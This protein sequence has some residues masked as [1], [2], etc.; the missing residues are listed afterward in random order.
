M[1][2][3]KKLDVYHVQ[4]PLL[5]LLPRSLTSFYSRL[6]PSLV[7]HVTC[8]GLT[9]L[10][11]CLAYMP[12]LSHASW[13]L[14][15]VQEWL[16]L[17]KFLASATSWTNTSS[18][19][20]TPANIRIFLL[21]LW[22]YFGGPWYT[23]LSVTL[24]QVIPNSNSELQRSLFSSPSRK[25]FYSMYVYPLPSQD[26]ALCTKRYWEKLFLEALKDHL[27]HIPEKQVANRLTLHSFVQQTFMSASNLSGTELPG[28]SSE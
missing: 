15:V 13:S 9:R 12:E 19:P 25:I 7:R 20:K 16:G 4:L 27:H 26:S 21:S 23:L 5:L 18:P 17:G 6:S 28:N 14:S 22:I 2:D 1:P 10:W 11:L 24:N 8:L 3:R